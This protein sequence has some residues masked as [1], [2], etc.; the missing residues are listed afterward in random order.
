MIFKKQHSMYESE[1][2]KFIKELKNQLPGMEER[3][4]AGRSLLWDK[5][6][7]SL[8]EQARIKESR[9]RQNAYPYQTKV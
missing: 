6:P 2:T 1:H 7:L 4:V 8:D 3:Q 5:A 9:L